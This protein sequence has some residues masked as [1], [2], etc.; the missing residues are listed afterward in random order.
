MKG[1]KEMKCEVHG[2]EGC[3]ARCC[4]VYRED[5]PERNERIDPILRKLVNGLAPYLN[6][7]QVRRVCR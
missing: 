4:I 2:I 3:E 1:G 7:E 6:E 5:F